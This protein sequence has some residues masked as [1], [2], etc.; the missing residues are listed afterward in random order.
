MS[1][2]K[3]KKG[4]VDAF[5]RGSAFSIY[6][7]KPLAFGVF[8]MV[9]WMSATLSATLNQWDMCHLADGS[10]RLNEL[11]DVTVDQ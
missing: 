11:V 9:R 3:R 8:S 4:D 1:K 10:P 5:L 7:E 2:Y 6:R